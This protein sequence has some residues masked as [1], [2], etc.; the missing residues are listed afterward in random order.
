MQ[1]AWQLLTFGEATAAVKTF[2]DYSVS[3][4]I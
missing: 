2:V 1:S 4:W 3:P